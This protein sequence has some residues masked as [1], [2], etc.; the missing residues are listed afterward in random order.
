VAQFAERSCAAQEAAQPADAPQAVLLSAHS[1]KSQEV[2][3]R[4]ELALKAASPD[5][6]AARSLVP[7]SLARMPQVALPPGVAPQEPPEVRSL[8]SEA[9][10]AA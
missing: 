10:Q 4:Q 7:M 8:L 5:E 2:R 1:Q 6:P 9:L 3:P